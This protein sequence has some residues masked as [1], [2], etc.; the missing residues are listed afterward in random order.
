LLRT[1]TM[2]ILK[3]TLLFYTCYMHINLLLESLYYKKAH[4]IQ[5][6]RFKYLS[7]H[8]D[9]QRK[10]TLFYTMSVYVSV[11]SVAMR[12]LDRWPIWAP[13]CIKRHVKLLVPAAF[14]VVSSQHPL[15]CTWPSWCVACSLWVFLIKRNSVPTLCPN[16]VSQ[17][18]GRYTLIMIT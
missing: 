2:L 13:P 16:S 18:W 11:V 17:H 6:N 15:I 8:R 10:T 4:Q 3:C 5:L 14:A 9:R 7:I 1:G 12:S